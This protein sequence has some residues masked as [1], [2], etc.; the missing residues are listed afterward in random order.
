MESLVD[1]LCA[2]LRDLE[3]GD[4]ND[5]K[6]ECRKTEGEPKTSLESLTPRD[7]ALRYYA[8]F[9]A[10][11]PATPKKSTHRKEK[12][13]GNTNNNNIKNNGLNNNN[14]NASNKTR[15]KKSKMS[16]VSITSILSERKKT[17]IIMKNPFDRR[18]FFV[19]NRFIQ[20]TI[21]ARRSEDKETY[22]FAKSM[23][24]EREKERELELDQ[25][26][27]AQLQAKFDESLEAL[28]DTGAGNGQDKASIWAAPSLS[29]PSGPLWPVDPG[30][31]PLTLPI[32]DC[33]STVDTPYHESVV[34][35]SPIIP[36]DIDL[37][38]VEK[39]VNESS[40]KDGTAGWK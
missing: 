2:K 13:F 12:N 27:L 19:R 17:T 39:Y 36:W 38:G 24:R 31:V 3:G 35:D 26:R 11:Q 14:K 9:P 40:S 20:Q 4:S 15:Q 8:A 25:L 16:I 1:E 7:R 33:V 21:D 32:S 37:I 23:E 34:D 6:D 10:L 5:D 22:G 18:S 30:E 29:I 28:W